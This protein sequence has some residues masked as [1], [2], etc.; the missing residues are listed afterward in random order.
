[1]EQNDFYTK[2]DMKRLDAVRHAVPALLAALGVKTKECY[3][4]GI[5]MEPV[6]GKDGCRYRIITAEL[7]DAANSTPQELQM[8]ICIANPYT[9]G[10]SCPIAYARSPQQKPEPESPHAQ[11]D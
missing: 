4:I 5:S 3:N 2:T 7:P 11:R 8:L 10:F 1:M 9:E 6:P